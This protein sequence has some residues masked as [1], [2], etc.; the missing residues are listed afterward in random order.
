MTLIKT[1][2][3]SQ[4][5]LLAIISG[6]QNDAFVICWHYKYLCDYPRSVQLNSYFQTVI[7]IPQFPTYLYGHSVVSVA[8]CEVLYYYF[9]EE[10][11]KLSEITKQASTSRLYAGVHFR[12][13]CV[14]GLKLGKQIGQFIIEYLKN[15]KDHDYTKVDVPIQEFLHAPIMPVY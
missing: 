1:Y 12:C 9:S 13:D 7:P 4:A 11:E 10:S 8:T 14:E 3:F 15:Q 5:R 2:N 6:T